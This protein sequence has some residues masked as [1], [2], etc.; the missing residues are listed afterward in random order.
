MQINSIDFKKN[1][2]LRTKEIFTDPTKIDNYEFTFLINTAIGFLF[3]IKEAYITDKKKLV[4]YFP[5]FKD[6]FSKKLNLSYLP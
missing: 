4:I 1:F 5:V 6:I 3:T 2:Y